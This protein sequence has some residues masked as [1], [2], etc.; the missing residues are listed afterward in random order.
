[1]WLSY[2]L[3]CRELL[4]SLAALMADWDCV[5]LC[6]TLQNCLIS[7]SNWS[8]SVCG[9]DRQSVDSLW[10]LKKKKHKLSKPESSSRALWMNKDFFNKLIEQ[11]PFCICQKT[12]AIEEWI[13]T[14]AC[15]VFFPLPMSG[16][17]QLFTR[18][19]LA[20][21]VSTSCCL[22]MPS[23]KTQYGENLAV[24][25]MF[26]LYFPSFRAKGHHAKLFFC[27]FSQMFRLSCDSLATVSVKHKSKSVRSR[28]I[29]RFFGIR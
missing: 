29:L 11:K 22:M 27:C 14:V 5:L 18:C 9:P 19:W 8:E 16:R 15:F 7:L 28:F 10:V 24:D 2:W 21:S 13:I 23:M 26:S 20:Y 4:G 17:C 1:M 6:L 3:I 25:H 12:P